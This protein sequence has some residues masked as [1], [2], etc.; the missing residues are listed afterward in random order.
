MIQ[1]PF[2]NWCYSC[3]ECCTT[4]IMEVIA[5]TNPV[6]TVLEICRQCGHTNEIELPE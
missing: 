3:E 6:K 2:E 1:K 5:T 4:N